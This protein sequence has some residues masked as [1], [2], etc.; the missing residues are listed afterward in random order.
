MEIWV[1]YYSDLYAKERD[2]G[3]QVDEAISQLPEMTDLDIPPTEEEFSNAI[4]EL[5]GGKAPGNDNI[6]AEVLKENKVALLL[7]VGWK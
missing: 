4:D 3:G 7:L 1:E 5:A 6:P 2:V